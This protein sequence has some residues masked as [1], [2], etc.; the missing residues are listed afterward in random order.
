[1][2]GLSYLIQYVSFG[3][4]FYLAAIFVSN[5]DVTVDSSLSA[6]FLTIFAGISAGNNANFLED[7]SAA[8]AAARSVFS[9]L[10]L[11]D[12]HEARIKAGSPQVAA[13]IKGNI[14]FC[15]VSFK[16]PSRDGL[17]LDHF[18]LKVQE[19]E[20][21]GLVGYSGSGK[22]TIMSLLLGFYDPQKGKITVEGLDI[23]D[24]DLHHLRAAFGIVSQEPILFNKSVLWNIRYNLQEASESAV[25]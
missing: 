22:S 7:I 21:I 16:Y 25:L 14:E 17:A 23:R 20:S 10:D 12:E 13:P 1:M 8:R 2:F 15:D 4:L 11:E 6:I 3:L 18:S 19:G 9:I 24:Y 5:F